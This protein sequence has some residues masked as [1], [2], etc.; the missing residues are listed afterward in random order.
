[1]STEEWGSELGLKVLRKLSK[2]YLNLVWESTVLLAICSGEYSP[3][4]GEFARADLDILV[5]PKCQQCQPRGDTDSAPKV[6]IL[7]KHS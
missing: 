3:D 5:P 4:F 2:L 6:C 7:L 1:M